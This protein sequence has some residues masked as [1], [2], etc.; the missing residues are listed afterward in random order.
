MTRLE[1]AAS[2][3]PSAKTGENINFG[4]QIFRI[5]RYFNRMGTNFPLFPYGFLFGLGQKL[6]ADAKESNTTNE[7]ALCTEHYTM[8]FCDCQRVK[9]LYVKFLPL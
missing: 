8:C 3:I 6:P 5:F 1:L 4:L 9:L 2:T 7:N